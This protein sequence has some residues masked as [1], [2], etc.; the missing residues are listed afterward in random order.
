MQ[1]LEALQYMR[2]E[3]WKGK[4]EYSAEL[5]KRIRSLPDRILDEEHKQ[6][7][8][9]RLADCFSYLY[10][11]EDTKGEK[12]VEVHLCKH[13]LCPFCKFYYVL[14]QRS[15]IQRLMDWLQV[16]RESLFL[17]VPTMR[18]SPARERSASRRF[19]DITQNMHAFLRKARRLQRKIMVGGFYKVEWTLSTYTWIG[20]NWHFHANCIIEALHAPKVKELVSNHFEDRYTFEQVK[21]GFMREVVKYSLKE[22]SSD[23]KPAYNLDPAIEGPIE[24]LADLIGTYKRRSLNVWGDWWGLKELVD[25]DDTKPDSR[26]IWSNYHYLRKEQREQLIAIADVDK[27]IVFDGLQKKKDQYGKL[28]TKAKG[29]SRKTH[30]INGG[31]T[32]N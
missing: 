19:D 14:R 20:G 18:G 26:L 3:Q 27:A 17:L 15:R 8:V 21:P 30:R 9:E 13:P 32:W 24:L 6:R 2:D 22:P 25:E 29:E 28:Y 16:P 10:L 7:T 5:Q 23:E 11:L 12:R 4:S 1:L 31:C